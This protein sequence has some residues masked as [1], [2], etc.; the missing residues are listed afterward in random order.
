MGWRTEDWLDDDK[1][2]EL[3]RRAR[4]WIDTALKRS[5]PQDGLHLNSEIEDEML[6]LRIDAGIYVAA[7]AMMSGDLSLF[8]SESEEEPTSTVESPESGS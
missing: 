5:D 1:V 6:N 8:S 7:L 3:K 2:E 4:E